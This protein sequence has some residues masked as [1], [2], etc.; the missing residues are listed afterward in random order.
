MGLEET[1]SNVTTPQEK[2]EGGGEKDFEPSA[3]E[4][5]TLEI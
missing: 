5:Q 3:A 4:F 2:E 1:T